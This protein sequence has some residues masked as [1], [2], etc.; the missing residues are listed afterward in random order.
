MRAGCLRG[1]AASA[2]VIVLTLAMGIGAN[3]AVFT[4][5]DALMLRWLPVP[6]PQQLMQLTF[7]SIGAR[8]ATLR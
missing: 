2:A 4:L 8:V 5:M 3:T 1:I 6:K 7:R